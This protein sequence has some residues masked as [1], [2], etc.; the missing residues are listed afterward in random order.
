MTLKTSLFLIITTLFFHSC[1][2]KPIIN[3]TDINGY[4][5]ISSVKKENKTIKHYN[6]NPVIDY[7][8]LVDATTGFR[9]KVKPQF[10]NTFLTTNHKINF[11]I[12]STNN[13]TR[14][15]YTDSTF[16]YQET[17]IDLNK[18][19]LIIKNP[20]TKLT[21]TYKPFKPLNLNYE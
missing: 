8:E 5:E 4:W 3:Y 1:K 6:I 17:I 19:E 12:N 11:T 15:N 10:N 16:N 20:K 14:I 21:Y 9:K 7:F 18:T 13:T 2:N